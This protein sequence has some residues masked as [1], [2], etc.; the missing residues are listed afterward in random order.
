MT[1]LK[2]VVSG[3]GSKSAN[4]NWDQKKDSHPKPQDQTLNVIVD[5]TTTT[6]VD[7]DISKGGDSNEYGNENGDSNTIEE[8]V[9]TEE[10]DNTSNEGNKF[11]DT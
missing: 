10:E 4:E 11:K 2:E 1:R 9:S 7:V 8:Y 5:N 3:Q 6:E